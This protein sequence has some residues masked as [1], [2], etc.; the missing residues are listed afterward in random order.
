MNIDKYKINNAVAD[1]KVIKEKIDIIF[2]QM[3]I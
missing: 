3:T 2:Y 1:F